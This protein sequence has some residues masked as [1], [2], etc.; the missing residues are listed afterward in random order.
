MKVLLISISNVGGGASIAFDRLA[1]S[2]AKSN[3]DVEVLIVYGKESPKYKTTI[4]NNSLF[5]RAVSKIKN[6]ISSY[7]LRRF[8]N[9]SHNYRSLDLFPSRL[10]RIINHSD[11]D[12][13]NIHWI[14]TEMMSVEQVAKIKKPVIW[15][16]HDSW[17]LNGVYHVSPKDLEP[18]Y[19]A[20]LPNKLDK[21]M[22]RR[23]R[24]SYTKIPMH[25]V[26]PSTWLKDRFEASYLNTPGNSCD[27]I[28]NL[29]DTTVWKPLDKN[30]AKNGLN[31]DKAKKHVLFIA[32]SHLN[33]NINKGFCFIKKILEEY[34]TSNYVFHFVGTNDSLQ[35]ENVFVHGRL[36]DQEQLV[37]YYSACDIVIIPSMSENMSNAAVESL[38][39]GTPILCFATTGLDEI[40]QNGVNG[41]KARKFDVED[42]YKGLI[43]LAEMEF[44]HP[45]ENTVEEYLPE[46]NLNRYIRLYQKYAK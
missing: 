21:W 34:D 13:V 18:Y 45:V 3:I 39:C 14:G 32:P 35:Y 28:R 7:V 26:T 42:L 30:S 29:I 44:P 19:T 40:V 36:S 41:Y 6:S 11:A 8:D 33:V 27:V 12:V 31:F 23:K 15:T 9:P 37:K 38:L 10:P 25:F 46:L 4:M 1:E 17:M 16:L 22:M 24:N 20:P 5:R 43:T 2:L